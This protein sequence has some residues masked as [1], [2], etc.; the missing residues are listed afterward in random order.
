[1]SHSL[2]TTTADRS[3]LT[4][5]E[6]KSFQFMRCSIFI[7]SV[8]GVV[9][10]FLGDYYDICGYLFVFLCPVLANLAWLLA[11]QSRFVLE[12]PT[13]ASSIQAKHSR[14]SV[15]PPQFWLPI[16]EH[17]L[18]AYKRHS[19]KQSG[20]QLQSP[21]IPIESS[22]FV[23]PTGNFQT[24]LMKLQNHVVVAL[25]TSVCQAFGLVA[26]IYLNIPFV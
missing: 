3:T 13:T 25:T 1:M 16:A 11:W 12:S 7:L 22:S 17:I 5:N 21:W 10:V 24:G 8:V 9:S 19:M 26:F 14:P 23:N 2:Q 4:P 15:M 6:T 20:D 18:C